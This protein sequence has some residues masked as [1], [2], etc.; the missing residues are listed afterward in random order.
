MLKI[1]PLPLE[2]WSKY[3]KQNSHLQLTDTVKLIFK[4]YINKIMMYPTYLINLDAYIFFIYL[5]S[6]S[7]VIFIF[8]EYCRL[9]MLMCDT[10]N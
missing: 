6:I 9:N 7:P 10:V 5:S 4:A 1:L 2:N 8:S 3:Q